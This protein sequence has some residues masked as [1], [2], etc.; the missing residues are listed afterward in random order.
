MVRFLPLSGPCLGMS[1]LMECCQTSHT[2]TGL[3][4]AWVTEPGPGENGSTL[5]AGQLNT[6]SSANQLKIILN[7]L[8]NNTQQLL[9]SLKPQSMLCKYLL[10]LYLNWLL[11]YQES[12]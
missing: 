8:H 7:N 9:P 11:L 12:F 4:W 3:A 5:G 2:N 1:C 6:Q 10:A